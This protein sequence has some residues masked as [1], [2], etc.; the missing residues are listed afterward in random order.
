VGVVVLEVDSAWRG[1][2]GALGATDFVNPLGKGPA[3][4]PEAR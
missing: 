3:T 1:F 2:V 4:A